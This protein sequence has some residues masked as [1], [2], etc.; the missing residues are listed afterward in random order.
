MSVTS[1]PADTRAQHETE[2]EQP[3]PAA[4]PVPPRAVRIIELGE[5]GTPVY[6]G[7]LIVEVGNRLVFNVRPNH[8][9]DLVSD[10]PRRLAA[11]LSGDRI[12]PSTMRARRASASHARTRAVS[13]LHSVS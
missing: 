9:M 6:A 8:K 2:A 5:N 1:G 3:A 11:L 13:L 4:A 7:L 12:P 10:L